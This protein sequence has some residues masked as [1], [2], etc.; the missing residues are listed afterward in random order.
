MDRARRRGKEP[1]CR[2][3]VTFRTRSRSCWAIRSIS[4]GSN[5]PPALVNRLIR[6]AAFQN[7]EFYAAQAM[8]LPTFGKPRIISCAELF[9]KHIALPRGC[10]DDLFRASRRSTA[11]RPNLRDERQDG[12]PL[13]TRFL[14]ELTPEQEVG[15]GSSISARNRC[16]RG[17][18]SIRQDR[19]CGQYDRCTRDG[20]PWFLVHRRQLLDQWVARLQAFLDI[21]PTR[22]G[23]SMAGR[24]SRQASSIS[25]S[26]R[27]WFERASCPIWSPITAMSSSMNAITSPPW[28][29]RPSRGP[30]KARYVLGLSATV[31]RKDG[32]HPIIFMQCGPVRHRVDA[33]KQAAARPFD[34]RVIFRRTEFPCS[35]QEH[36]DEKPAIQELYGRACSGPGAK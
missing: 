9:T 11:S 22:S 34:H 28:A 4:T 16:A 35:R 25:P 21:P 14:G 29:L 7:P 12:T 1:S 26:C 36:P 8:R 18:H 2:S 20:T 33:R 5:L 10:L 15:R 19:R 30:A 32:H 23:S 24:R 31:T 17:D 3:A 13:A 6:L 27:A